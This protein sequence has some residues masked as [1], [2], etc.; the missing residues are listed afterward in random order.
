MPKR[1]TNEQYIQEC[2]EL[3]IDLPIESYVNT[4]TKIKHKCAKCEKVYKQAPSY[5]LQGQGCPYC[6]QSHGEKFIQNYL[7]KHNIPYI[8][9]KKFPDCVYKNELPFDFYLPKQK[10]LIEYQ[11]LQHFEWGN[12]YNRTKKDLQKRKMIDRIKK[13][14][15]INNG[16]ILLDPTYKLDTQEK[17]N[18][19]LGKHL[20]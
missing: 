14:Y 12:L 16:Y 6:S 10:I 17:I 20:K 8:A 9:Q 7:D 5:H 19:Y 2:K 3:G 15:A 11:G 13:D 4:H 18:N 1:K